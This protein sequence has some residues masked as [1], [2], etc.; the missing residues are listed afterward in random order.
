MRILG[1]EGPDEQGLHPGRK[2]A[3]AENQL[4]ASIHLIGDW[5]QGRLSAFIPYEHE[6]WGS[7]ELPLHLK[8]RTAIAYYDI[9]DSKW[10]QYH[11]IDRDE[12]VVVHVHVS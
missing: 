7:R 11:R 6:D 4:L 12:M 3:R 1:K 2:K 10:C 9:V 5:R 8:P